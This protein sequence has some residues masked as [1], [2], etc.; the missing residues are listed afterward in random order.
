MSRSSGLGTFQ[1]SLT[2]SSQTCGSRPSARPNSWIAAPVRWPQ[3]PSARTVA[4]AVRSAPGSKFPSGWPSLPRPLSPVRTPR[5]TPSSTSSCVRRGLGQHVGAALLGQALLEAR[6]RRDGHDLV[7]VVLERRRGR[8][9]G[10]DLAARQHV[11]GL[12]G[13]LAEG[14]ALPAPVLARDLG[15]EL[16]QRRRAHDGAGE[17]VPAAGLRLLDDRDGDLAEALHRAARV[18]AEELQ[19][20]VGRGQPRR[21][22]ADDGDAH[23]DPLVLRVELALDELLARVDG[24]REVAGDDVEPFRCCRA[25]HVS[26]PCGPSPPR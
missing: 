19:E 6:H 1:T 7:A 2:P 15:E 8:D 16:L 24:R 21:P 11:D 20:A 17:V 25:G 23:L 22:A 4:L 3:Q 13:D 14:E 18:V 10:G 9:P 5:T 26:C 12:L